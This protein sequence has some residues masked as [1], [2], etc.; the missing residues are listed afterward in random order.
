MSTDARGPDIGLT[1]SN[2]CLAMASYPTIE[3]SPWTEDAIVIFDWLQTVDLDLV[4]A[5][6][7]AVKQALTDLHSRLE[8]II[9]YE[10]LQTD[11]RIAEARYEVSKN[12]DW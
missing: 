4:P 1:S 11:E 5:E 10:F 9:P 12:M 3:L 2:Y 6:H 7:K 8:E